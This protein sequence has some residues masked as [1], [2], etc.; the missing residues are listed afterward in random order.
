[1]KQWFSEEQLSNDNKYDCSTWGKYTDAVKTISLTN[2]PNNLIINLKKFDKFGAKIKSGV[3]FPN[4]FTLNDYITL[5][6]SRRSN[7]K[8]LEYELYAVINHEGKYSH[9]GHY[10]CHVKGANGSWFFCNDAEITRVNSKAVLGSKKA[11]ILFYKLKE[12]W[13]PK[14][15]RRDSNVSTE[16]ATSDIKSCE[17]EKPRSISKFNRKRNR[18][19]KYDNEEEKQPKRSKGLKKRS[20]KQTMKVVSWAMTEFSDTSNSSSKRF[21]IGGESFEIWTEI[22]IEI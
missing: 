9:C 6:E 17:S 7:T 14:K 21:K 13:R 16:D 4:Q 15:L 20:R 18:S 19:F 1:M 5:T 12:E 2:A 3:D 11:Y 10:N 8:D 22:S